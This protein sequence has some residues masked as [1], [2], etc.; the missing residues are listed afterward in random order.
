MLV[1]PTIDT[2]RKTF[3][4]IFRFTATSFGRL[5]KLQNALIEVIVDRRHDL[6]QAVEIEYRRI[7]Y[8]CRPGHRRHDR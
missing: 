1:A 2:P 7:R 5:L 4:F 6:H 8:D 3:T